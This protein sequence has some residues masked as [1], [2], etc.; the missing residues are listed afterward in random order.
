LRDEPGEYERQTFPATSVSGSNREK[1][2][3]ISGTATDA[4]RFGE[5]DAGRQ[6]PGAATARDR[7]SAREAGNWVSDRQRMTRDRRTGSNREETPERRQAREKK[8]TGQGFERK[9][10]KREAVG[11]SSGREQAR[12]SNERER[13]EMQRERGQK[14]GLN[15]DRSF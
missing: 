3:R 7:A 9:R 5:K 14:K 1:I 13:R 4:G 12:A 8:D 10:E 15:L 6:T 11:G 2:G